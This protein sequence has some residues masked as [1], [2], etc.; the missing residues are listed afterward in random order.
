MAVLQLLGK[1]YFRYEAD[2]LSN[3][4]FWR[5]LSAHWVHLNWTHWLLN[6]LG[7]LLL[8]AILRVRWH[9]V[10]WLSIILIHSVFI[11]A[12]FLLFN[13]QLNWYVGFSGV[14][15][16]LFFLAGIL[17]FKQ[18]KMMASLILVFVMTKILA[19]QFWGAS[20]SSETLLNAPVV[21]DA[22]AYGL[23]CG[24]ALSILWFLKIL[25]VK[26]NS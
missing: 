15:Y 6:S 5:V 3:G 10:F 25:K 7:L 20:V 9:S 26:L 2:V 12:A 21:V 1:E 17:S 22:H 18:D 4:E 8:V 23:I 11:S 13:A 19:E 24:L 14:L 16:G